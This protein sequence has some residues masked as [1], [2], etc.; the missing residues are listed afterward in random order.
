MRVRTQQRQQAHAII[1]NDGFARVIDQTAQNTTY[2]FS[3]TI[4]RPN[5]LGSRAVM[6]EMAI[7]ADPDTQKMSILAPPVD[8]SGVTPEKLV[9]NIL[10]KPANDLSIIAMDK[11]VLAKVDADFTAFISNDISDRGIK[12]TTKTLYTRAATTASS[13]ERAVHIPTTMPLPAPLVTMP[14]SAPV[15]SAMKR[16]TAR[17][18]STMGTYEAEASAMAWS[19]SGRMREPPRSVLVPPAWM[20][21]RTPSCS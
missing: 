16:P 4:D 21:G 18:S 6:L 11:S 1:L 9:E 17:F 13:T 8:A 7:V 14:A 2:E 10:T 19:T 3:Y 15:T 20:M 5:I 12:Q